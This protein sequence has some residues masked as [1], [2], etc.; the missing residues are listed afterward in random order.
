MRK[1]ELLDAIAARINRYTDSGD[2]RAILE[3]AAVREAEELL[4]LVG[5]PAS[6]TEVCYLVGGLYWCRWGETANGQPTP[7]FERTVDLMI[8]VHRDRPEQ[9]PA[10]LAEMFDRSGHTTNALRAGAA[11]NEG[12]R[13]WAEY[14]QTGDR[15]TLDQAIPF[16][17]EAAHM[18]GVD[19]ERR[20]HNAMG[21][22]LA[23]H[24]A[25]QLDGDPDVADELIAWLEHLL[26]ND[27]STPPDF[28][29]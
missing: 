12:D 23:L 18:P 20:L 28:R 13:L 4:A 11:S 17:R 24:Q 29:G 22:A 27:P 21:L 25:L 16:L 2:T 1:D 14:Q 9:V 5:D 19:P 15:A 3:P 8:H 7:D 10:M 26:D 6:D